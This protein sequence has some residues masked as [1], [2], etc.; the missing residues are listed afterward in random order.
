MLTVDLDRL[1]VRPGG[2][3]LDVGAG[4]GRHTYAALERGARVVALDLDVGT[5]CDVGGMLAA[6]DGDLPRTASGVLV[7]ADA[8]ALPFRDGTFDRVIVSEVLEHLPHDEGA[9]AE[10]ARVTRPGGRVAVSVP[11]TWPEAVC[12]ALSADYRRAPGGHIRIYRRGQ[13]A[14]RL[15][16]AGLHPFWV[17]HAH[18]LHVPYW[19]LRCALQRRSRDPLP[20]R[21]YR[22]ALEWDIRTKPR[23]LRVCERLLDPLLGKSLVLYLD[24]TGSP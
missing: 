18:A 23:M 10:V 12:W 4:T 1:D 17:H 20:V 22:R 19:W 21:L 8:A 3:V 6:L 2:F 24:R 14:S 11:R 9:I 15:L 16:R 7:G 5:L 13:L